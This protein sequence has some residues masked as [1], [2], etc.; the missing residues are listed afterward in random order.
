MKN[1]WQQMEASGQF[2]AGLRCDEQFYEDE[3][4]YPGKDGSKN[5]PKV[6]KPA[7]KKQGAG[8][9]EDAASEESARG[10]PGAY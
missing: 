1:Y 6:P 7:E 8:S 10:G 2:K 4:N 5:H 9:G 3:G